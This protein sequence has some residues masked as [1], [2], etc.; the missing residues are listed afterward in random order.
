MSKGISYNIQPRIKLSFP[1]VE[2]NLFKTKEEFMGTDAVGI[3][4]DDEE[5][6]YGQEEIAVPVDTVCMYVENEQFIAPG[7]MT[8]V[9]AWV[10]LKFLLDSERV[11][12]F[13]ACSIPL[14]IW[15]F[16]TYLGRKKLIEQTINNTFTS[17]G[18]PEEATKK[19]VLA[20]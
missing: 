14:K 11:V 19:K 20:A 3:L 16:E 8:P 17:F 15:N 13:T 1:F 6:A 7:E 2:G 4:K 10:R 5:R 18:K 9:S 12:W